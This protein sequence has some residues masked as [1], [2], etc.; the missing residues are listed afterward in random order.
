MKDIFIIGL[1]LI[2]GSISLAIKKEDSF[3]VKGFDLSAEQLRMAKS[4]G[5]IDEKVK[6]I[7]EG[8]VHAD[9]IVLAVPVAQTIELIQQLNQLDL[10]KRR[11]YYR[12]RL[13]K[14]RNC[15]SCGSV[16]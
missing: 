11:Y 7:E 3:H 4:L 5:V 13:N 6:S 12:C 8:A 2:G 1:G 14:A 10:K 9:L 16:E 15:A